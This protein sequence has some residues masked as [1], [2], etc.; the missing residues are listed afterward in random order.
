MLAAFLLAF[1]LLYLK[2]ACSSGKTIVLFI[3]FACKKAAMNYGIVDVL[4]NK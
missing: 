3:E 1:L 4:K 2:S